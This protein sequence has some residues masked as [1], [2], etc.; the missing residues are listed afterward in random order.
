ME[1]AAAGS[2]V[3]GRVAD[4]LQAYEAFAFPRRV[5]VSAEEL[6]AVAGP[7]SAAAAAAAAGEGHNG[8]ATDAAAG[9]S[10]SGGAGSEF[11]MNAALAGATRSKE[12]RLGQ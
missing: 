4:H 10:S 12:V 8:T 1:G 7:A 9:V 6:L 11:S 2:G 5:P 3:Q